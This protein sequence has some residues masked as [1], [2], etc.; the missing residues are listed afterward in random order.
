MMLFSFPYCWRQT[1]GCLLCLCLGRKSSISFTGFLLHF[2]IL[3]IPTV[4][5]LL[6]TFFHWLSLHWIEWVPFWYYF[7]MPF[8]IRFKLFIYTYSFSTKTA[9]QSEHPQELFPSFLLDLLQI[10]T[11]TKN[12]YSFKYHALG[13]G[14]HWTGRVIFIP[15]VARHV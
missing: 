4:F 7:N 8:L 14:R 9:S 6:C 12:K 11:T 10:T 13:L 1:V 5:S 15:V 2:G 3:E